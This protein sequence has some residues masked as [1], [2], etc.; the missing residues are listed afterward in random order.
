MPTSTFV[1]SPH[2]VVTSLDARVRHL[3]ALLIDLVR[4]LAIQGSFSFGELVGHIIAPTCGLAW[5]NLYRSLSGIDRDLRR[6]TITIA[7]GFRRWSIELLDTVS[8]SLWLNYSVSQIP[9]EWRGSD[10]R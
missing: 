4:V 1:L 2:T 7:V 10:V 9:R 8:P 5:A 3:G 6:H